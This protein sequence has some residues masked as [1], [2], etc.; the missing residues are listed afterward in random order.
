MQLGKTADFLPKKPPTKTDEYG[1]M[2]HG[3]LL[4]RLHS[5]I[6]PSTLTLGCSLVYT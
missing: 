5:G 4:I 3:A 6:M 2:T 1:I